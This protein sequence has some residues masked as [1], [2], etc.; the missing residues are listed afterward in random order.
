MSAV[1][2]RLV[3]YLMQM[4]NK[5]QHLKKKYDFS[6]KKQSS[7]Y[8]YL[9]PL[10]AN[11]LRKLRRHCKLQSNDLFFLSSSFSFTGVQESH[12]PSIMCVTFENLSFPELSY[13]K[14]YKD[15]TCV[16]QGKYHTYLSLQETPENLKDYAK[17]L[18]LIISKNLK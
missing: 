11:D 15:T 12:G 4:L 6:K 14:I 17:K 8:F 18:A 10:K 16:L 7:L 1:Q 3:A 2:V 5:K 9:P 13:G